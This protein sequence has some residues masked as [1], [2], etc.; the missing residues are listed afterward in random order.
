M[1]TSSLYKS[2]NFETKIFSNK[3]P[4]SEKRNPTKKAFE[5]KNSTALILGAVQDIQNWWA[6]IIHLS[7]RTP[8]TKSTF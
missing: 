5:Q 7:V 2:T 8:C 6:A 1:Q 3:K 4:R